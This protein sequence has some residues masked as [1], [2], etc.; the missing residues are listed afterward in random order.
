MDDSQ[1]SPPSSVTCRHCGLRAA[2]QPPA[3]PLANGGFEADFECPN[4]HRMKQLSKP[5]HRPDASG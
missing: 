1:Y 4:G 5:K 2:L 3:R